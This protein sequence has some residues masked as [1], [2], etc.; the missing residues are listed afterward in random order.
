M[1]SKDGCPYLSVPLND[2]SL[3]APICASLLNDENGNSHSLV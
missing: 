3:I 2:P 1:H